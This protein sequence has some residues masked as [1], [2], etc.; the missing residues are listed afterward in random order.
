MRE[1]IYEIIEVSKENDKVSAVYDSCMLICIVL[2]MIPLAFKTTN[3]AFQNIDF[4][5]TIVF[6]VD[7]A[8]CHDA[9]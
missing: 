2:S 7:F 6:I 1:R 4:F 3:I 9:Q 5:T 8:F